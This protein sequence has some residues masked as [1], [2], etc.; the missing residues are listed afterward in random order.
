MI[1]LEQAKREAYITAALHNLGGMVIRTLSHVEEREST[2]LCRSSD[3]E[4]DEGEDEK[5]DLR[6]LHGGEEGKR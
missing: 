3:G 6:E 2:Y 4:S 5:S 1:I